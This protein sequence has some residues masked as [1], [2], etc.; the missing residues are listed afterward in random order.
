VQHKTFSFAL[1]AA[2]D[3]QGFIKAYAAVFNNVDAG[4]D[5]ILPGA[6]KQSIKDAQALIDQGKA[7]FLATMLWNHDTD[8]VIGGWFDLAEDK[9]G[10]VAHGQI[11]LETQLGR[12]TYSNIK[13]GA[14]RQFSIGYDT[15]DYK[16]DKDGVRELSKLKLW[17]IS[18]V[19]F[20]MNDEALLVSVKGKNMNNRRT[21]AAHL[22]EAR[23]ASFP[24]STW[25]EIDTHMSE[26]L[27]ELD[28]AEPDVAKIKKLASKLA[29]WFHQ[30]AGNVVQD[31]AQAIGTQ[32]GSSQ[33]Y[34]GYDQFGNPK[35]YSEAQRLGKLIGQA[36]ERASRDDQI[37]MQNC[38]ASLRRM[39]LGIKEPASK[40]G[41]ELQEEMNARNGIRFD[42]ALSR[43]VKVS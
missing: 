12:E 3:R 43:W 17:E 18:P 23:K 14:I 32:A 36:W 25:Q 35:S 19:T 20:A 40:T 9:T 37:A 15:I 33:L 34:A 21:F 29:S 16:Y 13:M 2:D 8:V 11:N 27:A 10:L 4:N 22:S 1:K 39:R 38:A 31:L 7:T 6:F 24:D 28:K 26:I 5:R 42:A 30:P 41:A